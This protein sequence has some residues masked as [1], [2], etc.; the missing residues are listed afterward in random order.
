MGALPQNVRAAP[1]LPPAPRVARVGQPTVSAQTPF[2][3]SSE[4]TLPR[5][6][7]AVLVQ[8]LPEGAILLNP[9]QEIYFGLNEV[10]AQIWQLLPPACDELAEVCAT[11]ARRYP[12]V[13]ASVIESDVQELLAEL[14]EQGLAMPQP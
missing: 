14:V 13:E 4:M 9:E 1:G 6:N 11:I 10:G 8:E 12:D 2:A 5:P 7:P 3:K